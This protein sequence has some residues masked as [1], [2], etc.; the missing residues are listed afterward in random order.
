MLLAFT[1]V[2]V[3][4]IGSGG[5]GPHRDE[6]YF[7]AAGDHLAVGYPDQGPLTPAI[8]AVVGEVAPESLLALRIAPALAIAPNAR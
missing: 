8:A 6:L 5:Y 7:L 1:V 3:L 2:L 4:L